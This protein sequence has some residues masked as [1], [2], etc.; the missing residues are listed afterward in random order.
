MPGQSMNKKLQHLSSA[1]VL[2]CFAFDISVNGVWITK[3]LQTHTKLKKQHQEV[4]K[5]IF[6]KVMQKTRMM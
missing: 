2:F 6:P 5:K 3:Q 4:K 1:Q